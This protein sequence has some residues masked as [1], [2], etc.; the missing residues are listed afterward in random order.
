MSV[1]TMVTRKRRLFSF[2]IVISALLLA[3]DAA[4]AQSSVE[5]DVTPTPTVDIAPIPLPVRA[6]ATSVPEGMGAAMERLAAPEMSDPPTQVELGRQSYHLSCMVCHGDRG[7]GLTPE[8]RSVLD[9]VDRNCWQSRCHAPNHP[10]EGFEIPRT[11]PAIMGIGSLATFQTA[12]DLFAYLRESMPWPFPGIFEDD[13]YWNLTAFLVDAN[14]IDYG[15]QTIGPENGSRIVVKRDLVQTHRTD[16]GL[17][18]WITA[19]VVVLLM[20]TTLLYRSGRSP[21]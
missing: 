4:L 3:V 19:A 5:T 15:G 17:E 11:S 12:D 10:P 6:H 1:W 8:W 16:F 7:Q 21:S 9:P 14:D 2:L 13:V 20:G 18:R